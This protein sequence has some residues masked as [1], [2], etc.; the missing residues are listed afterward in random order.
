[1]SEKLTRDYQVTVVDSLNNKEIYNVI[2]SGSLESAKLGIEMF[3]QD[4]FTGKGRSIC[5]IKKI[6]VKELVL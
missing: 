4:C 1:M 6:V 3:E 2:A 5:E